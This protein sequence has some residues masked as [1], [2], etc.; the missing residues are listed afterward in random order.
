LPEVAPEPAGDTTLP[1]APSTAPR[2]KPSEP[3]PAPTLE[4]ELALLEQARRSAPSDALRALEQ[5]RQQFEHGML[6][7]E[8]EALRVETLCALGRAAE[9]TTA[10]ES[11]LAA[12]PQSPLRSRL[13][14]ACKKS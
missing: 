5:H 11:F 6:A 9:A 8:R 4:A 1:P 12:N 14:P 2:D 10:A 13:E 3:S 7:D